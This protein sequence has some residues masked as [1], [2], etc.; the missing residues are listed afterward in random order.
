MEIFSWFFRA[1]NLTFWVLGLNV[2]NL[3]L[4]PQLGFEKD[5]ETVHPQEHE[6]PS[7]EKKIIYNV[8]PVVARLG[9]L[10]KEFRDEYYPPK[11]GLANPTPSEVRHLVT[12]IRLKGFN[13]ETQG[14]TLFLVGLDQTVSEKQIADIQTKLKQSPDWRVNI[15]L[16]YIEKGIMIYPD[17]VVFPKRF[18]SDENPLEA[19]LHWNENL[20]FLT[21]KLDAAILESLARDLIKRTNISKGIHRP[22]ILATHQLDDGGVGV[23]IAVPCQYSPTRK[24]GKGWRV[25]ETDGYEG[26][27]NEVCVLCNGELGNGIDAI[28]SGR[29][30][31]VACVVG[32]Y[33]FDNKN[34]KSLS[35]KEMDTDEDIELE[36]P[37]TVIER[38]K[39]LEDFGGL[40]SLKKIKLGPHYTPNK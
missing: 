4:F 34:V 13:S 38:Q 3:C 22:E 35:M 26:V 18:A 39:W 24:F 23:V 8:D 11:C 15:V 14:R 10:P 12:F 25:I 40:E 27:S 21:E 17:A 7:A 16:S 37:K 5:D 31:L 6:Q 9:H 28:E 36:V 1:K 33:C 29:K 30:G 20:E 32:C 2:I 19:I